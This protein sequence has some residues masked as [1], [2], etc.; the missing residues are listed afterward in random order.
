MRIFESKESK[1]E[2]V[3]YHITSEQRFLVS[4]HRF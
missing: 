4:L 3:L 1:P 2:D